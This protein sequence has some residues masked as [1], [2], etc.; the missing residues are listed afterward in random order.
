MDTLDKKYH[1]TLA[2][3]LRFM[4]RKAWILTYDD[5]PKIRAMYHTW[6]NI[7]PYSLRYTANQRHYGK[8]LLIT[9]KWMQLPV[10]HDSKVL[11]W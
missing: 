9:P 8:E 4:A 7:R 3:K 5:C 10:F 11:R 6:A 2:N 1:H